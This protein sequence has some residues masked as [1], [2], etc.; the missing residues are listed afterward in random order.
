MIVI[1]ALIVGLT[2][3]IPRRDDRQHRAEPGPV[4]TAES[5]LPDASLGAVFA[6][7]G[8]RLQ[9]R[10]AVGTSVSGVTSE[11]LRAPQGGRLVQTTATLSPISSK[12]QA[13]GATGT[14]VRLWLRTG[15]ERVLVTNNAGELPPSADQAAPVV[16]LAASGR[17]LVAEVEFA[18]RRQS[19][20]LA[21]GRR[22]AGSFATLYR[23]V[24]QHEVEADDRPG[25]RNNVVWTSSVSTNWQRTPYLAG[26]G[27]AKK[28]REWLVLDDSTLRV[29]N[30][31][32]T[33]GRGE[34]ETEYLARSDGGRGTLSVAGGKVAR[35][36]STALTQDEFDVEYTPKGAVLDV[37]KSE[38]VTL[39]LTT[40]T[41]LQAREDTGA[42]AP[43]SLVVS[44]SVPIPATP[45][46]GGT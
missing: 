15:D 24:Q 45:V 46:V 25:R 12:G 39:R 9:L 28:G 17:D 20:Q 37:P 1:G 7:P 40:R 5:V 11:A 35:R 30:V 34:D 3:A 32:S 42:R 38:A 19:V 23:P 43:G 29:R 36:G 16:A 22:H 33:P 31:E 27:W 8:A 4:E 13:Q 14:K 44:R 10:F 41:P 6:L 26:L 18:G 2:W 21:S